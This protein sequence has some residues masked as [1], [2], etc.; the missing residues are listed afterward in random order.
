MPLPAQSVA[1]QGQFLID[2]NFDVALEGQAGR[3]T[4]SVSNAMVWTRINVVPGQYKISI[5][6]KSKGNV[7]ATSTA[8]DVDPGVTEKRSVALPI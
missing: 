3:S 5:N 8:V 2:G 6:A 7:T 4:D 1:G